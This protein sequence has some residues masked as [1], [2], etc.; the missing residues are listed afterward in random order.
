QTG[1]EGETY[2]YTEMYPEFAKIA[3][4]EGEDEAAAFF[5]TVSKVEEEHAKR[6]ESLLKNLES[7]KLLKKEEPVKW[8]CRKCG[9]IHEGEEPPEE[10]PLCNHPK[11][12]YEVLCENY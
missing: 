10:C 1:I 11:G 8:K 2:E 6:Y 12:Y 9:Y 5:E 3:R 7:G 4:E